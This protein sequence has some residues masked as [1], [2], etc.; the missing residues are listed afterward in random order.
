MT[1]ASASSSTMLALLVV[2]AVCAIASFA[3]GI[4]PIGAMLLVAAGI[5][6]ALLG[7]AERA[8]NEE[9]EADRRRRN[10]YRED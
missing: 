2:I 8:E 5:M 3:A 10:V 9:L 1:E 4:W 6:W 7:R